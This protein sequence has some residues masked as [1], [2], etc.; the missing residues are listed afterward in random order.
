MV[1]G[2]VLARL[3]VACRQFEQVEKGG[4]LGKETLGQENCILVQVE[5]ER[6]F[7]VVEQVR[8]HL[9]FSIE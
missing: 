2:L 7:N 5:G 3:S 9:L 4:K 8:F 6:A 1:H